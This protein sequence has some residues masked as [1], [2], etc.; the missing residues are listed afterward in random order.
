[1]E[2]LESHLREDIVRWTQTGLSE[3]EAFLVAT[4]RL[5]DPVELSEE[6]A[7]ADASTLWRHRLYWMAA[8]VFAWFAAGW[9]TD[10]FV[11]TTTGLAVGLGVQSG[12]VLGLSSFGARVLTLIAVVWCASYVY[13][14]GIPTGTSRWSR[15]LSTRGRAT[16]C[17]LG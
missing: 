16:A 12:T 9:L 17:L 13:H 5:G 3:Q 7:E 8:G 14:H 11:A 6:F 4:S 15:F 1:M 2:E 10:L